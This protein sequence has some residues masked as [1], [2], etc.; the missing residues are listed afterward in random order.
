MRGSCEFP[1]FEF[2][3]ASNTARPAE[4]V[5]SGHKS[6]R[7]WRSG[8][9]RVDTR[10]LKKDTKCLSRQ[11]IRQLQKIVQVNALSHCT[12]QRCR[13]IH[14]RYEIKSTREKSTA[15][16]T[17]GT[18]MGQINFIS[19]SK[20]MTQH[21]NIIMATAI[22]TQQSAGTTTKQIRPYFFELM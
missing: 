12:Y 18:T 2:R 9:S 19:T 4:R 21:I 7:L 1:T 22:Q 13:N 14:H 16:Q 8:F 10:N 11:K 20:T 5:A 15:C 17:H 3:D 6:N